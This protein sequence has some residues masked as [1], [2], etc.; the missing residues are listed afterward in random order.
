[1]NPA[2]LLGV[3]QTP[4]LAAR[5]DVGEAGA[6][7]RHRGPGQ[8]G[9]PGAP[10]S[11]PAASGPGHFDGRS[12]ECRDKLLLNHEIQTSRI[13]AC[14]IGFG[15]GRGVLLRTQPSA[16]PA[17]PGEPPMRHVLR[18]GPV[19]AIPSVFLV[20]LLTAVQ[21]LYRPGLRRSFATLYIWSGLGIISPP[22]WAIFVNAVVSHA[23]GFTPAAAIAIRVINFTPLLVTAAIIAIWLL[24]PS[25]LRAA[26][27]REARRETTADQQRQSRQ[28]D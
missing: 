13:C 15:R 6:D 21:A 10:Q 2:E 27:E 4:R 9:V 17:N 24:R 22:S 3:R 11:A 18:L 8:R 12:I 5:L 1:M 14:G 19:L 20:L 28:G 16:F 23:P 7:A 26:A 25:V